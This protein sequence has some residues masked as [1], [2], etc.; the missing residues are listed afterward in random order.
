MHRKKFMATA[1]SFIPALAFAR[2][3]QTGEETKQPFIV[4]A[5]E[6]RYGK[7]LFYKGKHPNNVVIAKTDTGGTFSVFSYTGLDKIGPS[8]HLHEE[9]D[10]IFWV[11]EGSY[12][13]MVGGQLHELAE[14]DTIFLPR[15]VAHSWIQLSERGGLLYA[16]HPAGTMEEF[17]IEMSERTTPPTEEEAKA[18]HR[19]HGMQL[20]GPG[21]KL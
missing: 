6:A 3:A 1:F 18:I 10:E 15:K 14:G 9:Q 7:P 21:L 11:T 4:R 16:V 13:F 5:G 2:M 17:F 20:I 12:R 19:Q 8:T